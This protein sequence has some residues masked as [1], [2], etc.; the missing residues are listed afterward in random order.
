M[1]N[2]SLL[3]HGIDPS[4]LPGAVVADL[5]SAVDRGARGAVRL[6]IE[7]R[8]TA[9]GGV[10]PAWLN[11][12]ADFDVVGMTEGIAGVRLRAPTLAEA[13]PERFGQGDLFPR[14]DPCASGLT[15][16]GESLRDALAGN[17]DSD[18]YD[19]PLL[20]AFEDFRRVLRCGVT[21]LEMRNGRR[22]PGEV[23][24]TAEGIRTVQ[25]L[26]RQTPSPQRVR[27]AGKVDAI[28]HSDR[29][30]TLVLEG[31]AVRGVLAEGEPESLS[32]YWGRL[33]VVSGTAHFRPSGHLLRVEADR[34]VPATDGDA[35]TWGTLPVPLDFAPDARSLRREQGPRS[36]INAVFGAWPGDETDDELIRL[37][38]ELS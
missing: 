16:L 19:E 35:Q 8:S 17:E 4:A 28:R 25:R 22:G 31:V 33:A 3:L 20:E 1:L 9:R 29:A 30:F 18:D 10:P 23:T 37:I 36:G 12:A 7:G 2:Y 11:Q 32:P 15:L 5:L 6:R 26:H 27:L 38:E 24:V 21:S 13:V 14:L 34:L